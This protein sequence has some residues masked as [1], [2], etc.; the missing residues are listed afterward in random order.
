MVLVSLFKFGDERKKTYL[1][2][3]QRL[4]LQRVFCHNEIFYFKK[5]LCDILRD[6]VPFVQFQH[7]KNTHG[8]VLLLVKCQK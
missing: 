8:G 2:S 5:T 7:V 3:D 1:P 6:L 4:P